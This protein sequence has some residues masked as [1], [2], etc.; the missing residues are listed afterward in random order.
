MRNKIKML[1]TVIIEVDKYKKITLILVTV[2]E[3][4]K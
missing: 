4:D 2:I 3:V 1:V